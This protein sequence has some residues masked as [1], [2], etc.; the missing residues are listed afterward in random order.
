MAIFKFSSKKN[1]G[2]YFKHKYQVQPP[3]L[4]P[5][6]RGG[7]CGSA[8]VLVGQK[9]LYFQRKTRTQTHLFP[10]PKRIPSSHLK[11]RRRMDFCIGADCTTCAVY[12]HRMCSFRKLQARHGEGNMSDLPGQGILCVWNLSDIS[13]PSECVIISGPFCHVPLIYKYDKPVVEAAAL[14]S[15]RWPFRTPSVI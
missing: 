15:G 13:Q 4:R 14:A 3:Q 5:I 8:K 12:S 7:L 1:A 6:R 11:L 2:L 9:H 10:R